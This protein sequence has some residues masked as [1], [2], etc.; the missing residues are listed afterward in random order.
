MHP[1]Q[2]RE[3]SSLNSMTDY[4]PGFIPDSRNSNRRPY[5]SFGGTTVDFLD[6]DTLSVDW[7]YSVLD[8]LVDTEASSC[9]ADHRC[10]STSPLLAPY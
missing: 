2:F 1:S 5:R 7:H 9:V 10:V 6:G 8:E 4:V 3:S